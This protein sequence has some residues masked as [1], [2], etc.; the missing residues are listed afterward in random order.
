MPTVNVS[1]EDPLI[2]QQLNNRYRLLT[3]IAQGGMATVYRAMD[4]RLD[5]VVAIKVMSAHL[6]GND[7]DVARFTR[8]AR[9]AAQLN[10]SGIVQVFDQGRHD[11]VVYL[12]MEYV[13]GWT[14]RD[15]LREHGALSP[16][17]S[18]EIM[19]RII[20]AL[21]AAH[22]AGIVHWDVKPE[23]VL[24]SEDGRVKVADFG[25]ARVVDT[26]TQFSQTGM[27]FGTVAYLAPEQVERG[28]SD[29]RSDVY[30]AGVLLFEMLTGTKPFSGD[31]PVQ[32]ALQHV[33][34]RVPAP[35]SRKPGL[36]PH[37]DRLIQQ[38]TA[39]EPKDRPADAGAF[40][41]LLRGAQR[42]LAYPNSPSSA[43]TPTASPSV[44]QIQPTQ[45]L[46]ATAGS[47]E[48]GAADFTP[49]PVLLARKQRRWPLAVAVLALIG[50]LLAGGGWYFTAGPGVR[51]V[52]PALTGLEQNQAQEKI[53][54]ND[55][56]LKL[57]TEFS[58]KA[59]ADTVISIDPPAG[60][61]VP[62]NTTITMVVSRGPE[63]TK[64]PTVINQSESAAKSLLSKARL[65]L[66]EVTKVYDE[67]I[68]KGAVVSSTPAA[69]GSLRVDTKVALVLSLGPKP[70]PVKSWIG[71]S[72]VAAQ[73][74]LTQ[75]G[76]K[77]ESTSQFSD[78]VAKGLV[79]SQTPSS[80]TLAKDQ[81]VTLV[82]SRGPDVVKVPNVVTMPVA[83][84][85]KTLTDAG[86]QV[87]IQ[88]IFAG[89]EKFVAA[90]S[91]VAGSI[92]KR[93]AIVLLAVP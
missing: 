26:H 40:L 22:R 64:V 16:G 47:S 35:S 11:G 67:N 25:L 31:S 30:A 3:R 55:L 24:I 63:L 79:I 57:M 60:R 62:Q 76:L 83:L 42:E 73:A 33:S 75:S 5:R 39:R 92:V 41:T 56:R 17:R 21:A 15:V 93:G 78:S 6:V 50:A 4:E 37:L 8:E 87:R 59:P 81:A 86:F 54:G 43:P 52:V 80:G 44:Q 65:G 69:G 58:D 82:V 23:N 90:Q 19:G 84:A 70:I 66:G 2:G 10:H 72:A 49:A 13:P 68:A 89:R 91:P 29:A 77:P 71:Q 45:A 32:V 18:L 28:I 51:V 12:A 14:L 36:S 7:A 20:E 53:L 38:V 27:L 88:A 1:V 48:L 74:A 9:S 61:K 34:S 46:P 85:R